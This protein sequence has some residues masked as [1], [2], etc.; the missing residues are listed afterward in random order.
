MARPTH[1]A[2]ACA[3]LLQ[4]TTGRALE[5]AR[6]TLASTC[7]LLMNN[8]LIR[9]QREG[10][11]G[12][13]TMRKTDWQWWGDELRQKN[14]YKAGHGSLCSCVALGCMEA[15]VGCL[16]CCG[17]RSAWV[18]VVGPPRFG[19]LRDLRLSRFCGGAGRQHDWICTF[20]TATSCSYLAA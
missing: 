4:G 11:V 15:C 5:Y 14:P 17:L 8:V 6:T 9:A 20:R 1:N 19:C 18:G 10:V 12:E 13:V 3:S 2:S 16:I 7:E